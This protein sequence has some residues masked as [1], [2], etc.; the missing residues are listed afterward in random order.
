MT[1][2]ARLEITPVHKGSMA[3]EIARAVAALD[4][5]DVSYETTAMDTVIEAESTA[6]VFAAAQAAH[7]AVD[8]DRIITSLEIDDRRDRSEHTAD[9]VAAVEEA[10]GRPPKRQSA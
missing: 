7:E 4:D 3:E 5:F 10:L 2:I 9:R 1:V 8:T 6:E